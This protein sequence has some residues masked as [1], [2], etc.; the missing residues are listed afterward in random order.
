MGSCIRYGLGWN[1]G[2]FWPKLA[3]VNALLLAAT[4]IWT[5]AAME[6]VWD[7]CD[8]DPHDENGEGFP[9]DTMF[10]FCESLAVFCELTTCFIYYMKNK[11]KPYV[12]WAVFTNILGYAF[13]YVPGFLNMLPIIETYNMS[14]MSRIFHY[15]T[16]VS[17]MSVSAIAINSNDEGYTEIV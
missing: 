17:I 1:L 9:P 5:I 2:G 8:G 10:M 7:P 14:L 4:G 13:V 6:I 15:L 3:I 11:S 16:L 12:S